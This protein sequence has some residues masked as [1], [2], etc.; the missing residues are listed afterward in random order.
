MLWLRDGAALVVGK[1]PGNEAFLIV[2]AHLACRFRLV[3]AEIALRNLAFQRVPG[4][5][6]RSE[7]FLLVCIRGLGAS[8]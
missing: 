7:G 2:L 1:D 5:V 8:G 4:H 6:A 3:L